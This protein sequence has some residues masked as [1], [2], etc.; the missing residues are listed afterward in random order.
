MRKL[1]SKYIV[2]TR[3]SIAVQLEYRVAMAIWIL[4][5]SFPLVMMAVWLSLAQDGPVG[6]FSASDFVGYYVLS[7][8]VR[9]MTAVWVAWELDYD[10]RHGDLNTK[11]LHPIQPIH[12]YISFNLADKVIRG[13]LFTPIVIGIAWLVPAIHL[14]PTA[15]NVFFFVV[16]LVGAWALRYLTQ[17]SL[18][19]FAFWFSQALV[20]TDVFWMLYL[21]FGGG[22]APLE[23]LPEPLRTIAY[24]L[25]FRFMMSFPIEIM[26]GRLT[27]PEIWSGMVA[28]AL[29]GVVL[30]GAY[31]VLWARGM[32]R[33]G[34]FGA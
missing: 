12:D 18:G 20:L 25:P 8:Y 13:L 16:A 31:R 7:F 10:I 29:W 11:L 21:L 22:I 4:S 17:F 33:F 1:F 15:S 26:M 5:A 24:Y 2:L 23:L 34:A 6:T 27:A 32:R 30:F 19:M 14:A 9:Q 3:R 28:T